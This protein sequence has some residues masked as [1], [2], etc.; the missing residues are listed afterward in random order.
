MSHDKYPESFRFLSHGNT[1]PQAASRATWSS[2]E[3]ARQA[4]RTTW[5]S[6]AKPHRPET[7]Y[8]HQPCSDCQKEI[9]TIEAI[10]PPPPKYQVT[11][12]DFQEIAAFERRYG[13]PPATR[14]PS[15]ENAPLA[16]GAGSVSILDPVV[17]N[18]L[19]VLSSSSGDARLQGHRE[20]P[21]QVGRDAP[22]QCQSSYQHQPGMC[23]QSISKHKR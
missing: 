3:I 18:R 12:E 10:N 23:S 7:C 9:K 6:Q 21:S 2:A 1:S 11:V 4:A 15:M 5:T 17:R 19:D 20:T 13:L 14:F 8:W 22:V 16:G